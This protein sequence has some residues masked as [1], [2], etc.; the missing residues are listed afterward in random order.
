MSKDR[1][2]KLRVAV[3]FDPGF[4][5]SSVASGVE[6]QRSISYFALD[7]TK[8]GQDGSVDEI[9][10]RRRLA[11]MIQARERALAPWC[12]ECNVHKCPRLEK[13]VKDSPYDNMCGICSKVAAQHGPRQI[14]KWH[15]HYCGACSN[16]KKEE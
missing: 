15:D 7:F 9:E 11:M 10:G 13:G 12:P 8:E 16:P 4:S 6:R 3:Q 14:L 2:R 1:K 5:K